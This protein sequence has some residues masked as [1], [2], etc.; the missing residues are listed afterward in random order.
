[1]LLFTIKAEA[2]QS[3]FVKSKCNKAIA[4]RQPAAIRRSPPTALPNSLF[5]SRL[6]RLE[7]RRAE[8]IGA[9]ARETHIAH[10]ERCQPVASF[11]KSQ[12]ERQ[13]NFR[14]A[15]LFVASSLATLAVSFAQDARAAEDSS[16]QEVIVTARR[17]EERL[18]DVPI[19]ITVLSQDQLTDRSVVSVNELARY[20][21]SLQ[22]NSR[23]GADSASFSI[24]GFVQ[25]GQTAPSVAVYFADVVAPRAQGGTNAGNGAGP[26]S[27]FDLQNVQVL[28]GPQGTLFGRNT[29]GGAVL[30]VPR[31]P[32]SE[33]GGYVE[34]TAG[35]YGLFREQGVFN[36]P[37]SDTLR[38][39]LGVD[40]EK[41][42]GY[43]KNVSGIGPNDFGDIDY[44]AVRLSV[45]ADLASN[46]E[47]YTI[48][49]YSHSATNGPYPKMLTLENVNRD[50]F[51]SLRPAQLAATSGNYWDVANGNPAAQEWIQEWQI[52]NTTTWKATDELTL[53]N[54]A[55]YSRFQQDLTSNIYGENGYQ[56][57][58]PVP[59]FPTEL[60]TAPGSH[61][62]S[63]QT[64]TE[65]IQLQ[66]RGLGD[67]LEYQTGAYYEKSKPLDGIQSTYSATNIACSDIADLQ[68]Q[69]A[70][71]NGR[72]VPGGFIQNSRSE[73]TF[74]DI[75]VYAQATFKF[76]EK[77][78]LTGGL[79]YTSDKTDGLGQ[80]LKISFP[81]ANTPS[82]GCSQPV[83]VV[84][85]GTP[86][87]VLANP[88]LCDFARSQKSDK[89][90][91]LI[92][93]DYK[94]TDDT[95]AYGKY[96]RGYREGGVNVSSYG[97]EEWQ[98][99][100]V[101][102]Y[103]VGAKTSWRGPV[104][105]NFNVAVFYN[106]FTNQQIAINTVSCAN[107]AP[108]PNFLALY[109]ACNGVPSSE[110]PS[111]A[112]G[113]GNGGKSTI[114]GVEVD[115]LFNL[116]PG[117]DLALGY[118][119]LDTE[120]KSI[121]VPPVQRGFAT[122][123]P[124][125]IVGGTLQNTPR[126]KGSVQPSY[127]L[128]LPDNIGKITVSGTYTFQSRAFGNNSSLSLKTLPEQKN[129][130]LNLNWT[131]I[132]GI[133]LDAGLFATNVTNQKYFLFATGAS[134]GWDSVVLNEPRMYG[135]RLRYRFGNE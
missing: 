102:L 41:R 85:G 104:S 38:L 15:Y 25:E 119:Y 22:T 87:Q 65:E 48:G 28:K 122:Y 34:G 115:T 45:V 70:V 89:P 33:L 93:L 75:G 128:P 58:T 114:K 127:T 24:R 120:L 31:K 100:K 44:T 126:N 62:A 30:L 53:K 99:E 47:N 4:A 57:G 74:E 117:F 17:V 131:D 121:V 21:P 86:A 63:E 72:I 105:G 50:P 49:S 135:V 123:V 40:H 79:R 103:E 67:R 64:Y 94:P 83:P 1:V 35:D 18:Q 23:F 88:D 32:T 96:A 7:Y 20:V 108:I 12:G 111:A 110:Y 106:N 78:S 124:N 27:F 129:L 54:I 77:L 42:D 52:I 59:Y 55:S 92:D 71:A 66:G 107:V 8:I 134:F 56:N 46:V 98:P 13:V 95:L 132:A 113:I 81:T 60:T 133:K 6:S 37:V 73:Y 76:T 16:L 2:V 61:N 29:T 26:G 109:P 5:W 97:L 90:T 125:A 118:A 43:L 80:V 101:D 14:I 130:N 91:W 68:C 11:K 3:N 36:L 112:Q 69:N 51:A 19:S 9:N 10:D 84:Q 82:Y 39:R 116:F